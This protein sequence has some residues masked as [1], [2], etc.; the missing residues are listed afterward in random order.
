MILHSAP[1]YVQHCTFDA[2]LVSGGTTPS[3][4]GDPSANVAY[5]CLQKRECVNGACVLSVGG[6][7]HCPRELW[8]LI[9]GR[10]EKDGAPSYGTL[11]FLVGS[12]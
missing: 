10:G 11:P 12:R 5:T 2:L 6:H 9:G 3:T 1:L 4:G 8:V 7:T